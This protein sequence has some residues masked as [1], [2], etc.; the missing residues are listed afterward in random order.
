M[1]QSPKTSLEGGAREAPLTAHD[2]AHGRQVVRVER[3]P[4]PE[5]EA[6]EER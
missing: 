4:E 6:E 2:G 5:N 3:M 1:P